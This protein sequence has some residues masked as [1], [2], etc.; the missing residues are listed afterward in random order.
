MCGAVSAP[1]SAPMII[2]VM[3][4]VGAAI[5]YALI[6]FLYPPEAG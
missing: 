6:T 5:A 1:S 3:H 2:V 4:L